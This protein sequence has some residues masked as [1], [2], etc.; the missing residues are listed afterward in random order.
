MADKNEIDRKVLR[1]QVREFKKRRQDYIDYA[2]FL[3]S[4]LNAVRDNLIPTALV[5]TRAKEVAS[6]AGKVVRRWPQVQDAVNKFGDLAGGRMIVRLL[7][8]IEMVVDWLSDHFI[9]NEA[10]NLRERLKPDQ[11]GYRSVHL[12]VSVDPKKLP[13]EMVA[14]SLRDKHPRS[15]RKAIRFDSRIFLTRGLYQRIEGLKAEIQI[16]TIAQHAWSDVGHDLIYK[17]AFALPA[18]HQRQN[19]KIAAMLEEVDEGFMELISG[20]KVL[21]TNAGAYK[22]P[23]ECVEEIDRLQA[24][25]E[26]DPKNAKL[27]WELA[28]LQISV[29]GYDDAIATVER[30]E[31]DRTPELE[32]SLAQ[33]TILKNRQNPTGRDF[34]RAQEI[35]KRMLEPGREPPKKST[36]L[37]IETV[38]AESFAAQGKRAEALE[39]FAKAFEADPFDPRALGGYLR[40]RIAENPNAEYAVQLLRPSIE[41]AIGRCRAQIAARVNLPF[42]LFHLAEFQMLLKP[43]DPENLL[44]AYDGLYALCRAICVTMANARSARSAGMRQA[45]L[46]LMLDRFELLRH[47]EGQFY[48]IKWARQTLM[49]ALSLPGETG[50]MRLHPG[51]KKGAKP[52]ELRPQVDPALQ[53]CKVLIIAGGCDREAVQN[54]KDYAAVLAK[55]LDLYEGTVICGGTRE[56]ISGLVGELCY[57]RR[58]RIKA[59]GY[60]PKYLPSDGSA[61]ANERHYVICR[62][63]DEQPRFTALEPIQSW[64]D[65][66]GSGVHPKQ[67]RLIGINGGKIAGFEYHLAAML[68]AGVGVLRE[69]GR[70]ADE[71]MLRAGEPGNEQIHFLPNDVE[72]LGA[73]LTY[74][75]AEAFAEPQVEKLIAGIQR[76]YE[77]QEKANEEAKRKKDLRDHPELAKTFDMSNRM[78]AQHIKEKLARIGKEIKRA[79]GGGPLHEFTPRE[80]ELLA[81]ME[82]GRWVIERTW[83]GWTLGEKDSAKKQRPQLISWKDLPQ[84]ERDKDI[85]AVKAIPGL[86]REIGY[87]IVKAKAA[88]AR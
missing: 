47:V 46:N 9:I 88:R 57:R 81:E 23:K 27:A 48:W 74:P 82:H 86:L 65:L 33:A 60:L 70:Q 85:S 78:Q 51:L 7:S 42:A 29:A 83:A 31:G 15:R 73:L 5:N 24:T 18:D 79:Q 61:T 63:G 54:L 19:A 55:V 17:G 32:C 37:E 35:L 2:A 39:H 58:G 16:R 41:A 1:R 38:L 67:V 21:E 52:L 4:V 26:F 14:P 59:I 69:S 68:G 43:S 30:F 36:Y 6:F 56:G 20:I 75:P 84:S 87:E 8:D 80:I 76:E 77:K 11:F 13:P 10:E 40:E 3:E 50:D 44:S 12:I 66:I 72:T 45:I 71:L 34:L 62:T 28:R 64:I 25:S 53:G 22:S 49:L